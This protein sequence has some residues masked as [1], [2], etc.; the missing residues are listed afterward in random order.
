[1]RVHLGAAERLARL[2]LL[3]SR[4]TVGP[5][6]SA[7]C[8][9]ALVE[10]LLAL[11]GDRFVIRDETAQ[12]TLGGGV[13]LHPWAARHRRKEPLLGETL[14]TL[15]GDDAAAIVRVFLEG[16]E[17]FAVPLVP[18]AQFLNTIEEHA[19]AQI[20]AMRDLRVL[21]L[22]GERLYTTPGKWDRLTDAVTASLRDFHREHPLQPG[23]EMEDVRERRAGAVPPRVFRA[24]VDQLAAEQVIAR[25]G[26]LLRMP[27][28]VVRLRE[29]EQ[30]MAGRIRTLLEQTPMMPPDVKQIERDLGVA[31]A[32]LGEVLRVLERERTIV[33]VAPDLYFPAASIDRVKADLRQHLSERS[34]IT[35]ATFRDLFGTTRKY[36]IP[37]LEY[38]DR[39]GITIR[40]GDSRR[41]KRAS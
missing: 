23:R 17:S 15:A 9:V 41:L 21:T 32:K 6:E 30:G 35:P 26:S 16:N 10:P 13:V 39:E 18:L 7:F 2:V 33:R 29:D 34:E 25:D 28:H 4:E 27:D 5:R 12:R 19:A 11:R 37:L 14:T 20:D 31:P 24:V 1:V 3:D 38:L 8:Q 22:D 36:A 40:V